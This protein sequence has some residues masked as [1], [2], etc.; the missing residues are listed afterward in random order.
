ML[1]RRF[2]NWLMRLGFHWLSRVHVSGLPNVPL[3]GR[4]IL[5]FNHINFL[6]APLACCL[7]PRE[8]VVMTKRENFRSLLLAPLMVLY[9]AF[10]V[11]RG[12]VDRWA[13]RRATRVLQSEQVLLIAP[14]GTR[15]R[16]RGLGR[17]RDGMTLLALRSGSPVIPT[18]VWGVEKV[19]PGWRRLRLTDLHLQ[20]GRPFRF[21]AEGK[22]SRDEVRE[23]TDAS[24][25]L[26]AAM[27][28]EP[29]R[30]VYAARAG[31]PFNHIVQLSDAEIAGAGGGDEFEA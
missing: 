8:V 19:V 18:A 23:M 5:M 16:G 26:L 29:H 4:L 1:T 28:P 27:L 13:L 30:G 25:R 9:G 11:K 24:M 2:L 10:P 31:G 15:N 6:D 21:V 17:G 22:V 14:E 3:H 7:F 12:E 20:Y